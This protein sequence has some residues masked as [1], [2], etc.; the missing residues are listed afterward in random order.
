[1][2]EDF[3][4]AEIPYVVI[5]AKPETVTELQPKGV[6]Y[7]IG[8]PTLDEV[9][10]EGGIR[11][12]M[13]L[14]ARASQRETGQKLKMAGANRV[15]SPYFISERRMAAMVLRPVTSDF[16]DTVSHGGELE[17]RLHEI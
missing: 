13:G 3:H 1:M 4:A 16:L 2:A 7:L 12:A 14:V 8:D 15:I 11:K 6:P 17:F 5:D 10:E 9:L